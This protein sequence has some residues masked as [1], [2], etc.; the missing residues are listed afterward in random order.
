M[1]TATYRKLTR[2]ETELRAALRHEIT[3]GVTD[4]SDVTRLYAAYRA[5]GGC[6]HLVVMECEERAEIE[7]RPCPLQV[8]S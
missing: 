1:S 5:A 7:K 2:L 8:T 4:T 3:S 6:G